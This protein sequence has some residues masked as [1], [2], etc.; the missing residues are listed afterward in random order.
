MKTGYENGVFLLLEEEIYTVEEVA[1]L[2]KVS[3][4]TVYDLIKKDELEAY[5]VGRQ[6]RIERTALEAYKQ[7]GRGSNL[8][9]VEVIE[10]EVSA[11]AGRIIISGQD[12]CMDLLARELE[13]KGAGQPLRSQSGSLDG[14]V[15]M[16][17]GEADIVS[18]HLFDGDTK[19]YNI[20]RKSVV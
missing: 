20:D 7:R 6:M 8:K 11:T 15:S 1:R 13:G 9:P 12:P 17:R 18:T 19:T 4:L 14:L 3:K 5:R 2:L 10:N 16:Y